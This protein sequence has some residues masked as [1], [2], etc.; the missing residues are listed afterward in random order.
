MLFT[1]IMLTGC[2]QIDKIKG[3]VDGLTNP[4]VS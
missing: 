3:T 1:L 4:L 2:E